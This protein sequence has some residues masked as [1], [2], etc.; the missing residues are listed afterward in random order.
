MRWTI[1]VRRTNKASH[2]ILECM[3]IQVADWMSDR[4]TVKLYAYEPSFA[5]EGK[6]IVQVLVGL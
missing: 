5:S 2:Y 1:K 3:D 4:M 6:Q